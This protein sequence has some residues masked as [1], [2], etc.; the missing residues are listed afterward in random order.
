MQARVGPHPSFY[1]THSFQQFENQFELLKLL[2]TDACRPTF[3]G[4]TMEN[5][6]APSKIGF[7]DRRKSSDQSTLNERRQFSSS[8]DDLSPEAKELAEA[9]DQYK[10]LNRR[11]FVSYE[12]LLS[13]MKSLGYNR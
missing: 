4:R 5:M 3:K 12:E 13:V 8:H 6:T 7:V 10:L 2:V 1:V 9:V 11:R